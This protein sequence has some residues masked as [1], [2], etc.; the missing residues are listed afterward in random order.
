MS[1]EAL[2]VKG[3]PH[4]SLEVDEVLNLWR[5][6]YCTGERSH[7]FSSSLFHIYNQFQ[8]L[9][10]MKYFENTHKKPNVAAVIP[11]DLMQHI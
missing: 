3:I 9:N 1:L 10:V 2:K 7:K 5:K 8:K 6:L 4:Q 11:S